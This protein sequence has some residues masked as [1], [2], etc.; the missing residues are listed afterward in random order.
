MNDYILPRLDYVEYI[1]EYYTDKA[2]KDRYKRDYM[3]EQGSRLIEV[4]VHE[5]PFITEKA[6]VAADLYI[7]AFKELRNIH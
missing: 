5:D 4:L 7:Q 3:I 6:I 2:H 1:L